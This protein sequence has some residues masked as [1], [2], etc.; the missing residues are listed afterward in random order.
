M[1]TKEFHV[2]SRNTQVLVLVRNEAVRHFKGVSGMTRSGASGMH[3][4]T[5]TPRQGEV[6]KVEA[7]L[8]DYAIFNVSR[9]GGR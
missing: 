9:E 6:R 5:I 3:S 4:F 8:N 1:A 7:F 2:A